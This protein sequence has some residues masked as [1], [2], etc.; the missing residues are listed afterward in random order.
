MSKK[1]QASREASQNAGVDELDFPKSNWNGKTNGESLKK[2]KFALRI[3]NIQSIPESKYIFVEPDESGKDAKTPVDF[4]FEEL[5]SDDLIA[6]VEPAQK[7]DNTPSNR[8]QGR[9]SYR[10]RLQKVIDRKK[11]IDMSD[12][13]ESN[14]EKVSRAFSLP[15][16]DVEVQEKIVN[17]QEVSSRSFQGKFIL[18]MCL[19]NRVPSFFYFK[20][21]FQV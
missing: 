8:P 20:R 13:E 2:Y 19:R 6:K 15:N 14:W 16:V 10:V 11:S 3:L 4:V 9:D 12:I 17:L 18:D 1:S 21:E 5:L 7:V